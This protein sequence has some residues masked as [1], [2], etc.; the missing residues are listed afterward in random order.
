MV[1]SVSDNSG[2][3]RGWLNPCNRKS[4]RESS[5]R[6]QIMKSQLIAYLSNIEWVEPLSLPEL[7]LTVRNRLLTGFVHGKANQNPSL[8]ISLCD[9]RATHHSDCHCAFL[10]DI[11]LALDFYCSLTNPQNLA[12]L[13]DSE[14]AI[15]FAVAM[16]IAT[17]TAQDSEMAPAPAMDRGAACSDL[18]MSGAVFCSS[19][20]L[21][22]LALL[23]N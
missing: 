22:L 23:K 15:F 18:G 8:N 12:T 7:S 1:S 14:M 19:L 4:W 2:N 10:L 9:W 3:D 5:I 13:F 6:E 21:S 16:Y 11:D 20:L 17:V